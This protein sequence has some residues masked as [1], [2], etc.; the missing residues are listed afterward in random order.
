M[1][2]SDMTGINWDDDRMLGVH[3]I[4]MERDRL[5]RIYGRYRTPPRPKHAEDTV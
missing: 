4:F 1:E 2:S 5:K 3:G